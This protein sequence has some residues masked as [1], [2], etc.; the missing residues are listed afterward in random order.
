ML[1]N[2]YLMTD[3]KEYLLL[4]LAKALSSILI[5]RKRCWR[6]KADDDDKEVNPALLGH[7]LLSFTNDGT[8]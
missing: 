8:H 5:I 1:L 7:K 3:N 6:K 4:V 2:T